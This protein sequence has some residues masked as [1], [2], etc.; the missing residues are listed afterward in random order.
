MMIKSLNIIVPLKNEEKTIE[1]LIE[2]LNPILDKIDKK[3]TVTLIDDHST[4]DTLKILKRKRT[5]V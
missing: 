4:D 3:T 1:N 5:E 2:K